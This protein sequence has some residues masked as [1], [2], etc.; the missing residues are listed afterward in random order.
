MFTQEPDFT[1]IQAIWKHIQN[2]RLTS[3]HRDDTTELKSFV[4]QIMAVSPFLPD[5]QI[6]S[7]YSLLQIPTLPQ[8]KK[9]S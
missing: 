5:D 1:T 8:T 6:H 7:T 2:Y 9:I 3:S 4:R